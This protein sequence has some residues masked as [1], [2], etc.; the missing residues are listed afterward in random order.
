MFINRAACSRAIAPAVARAEQPHVTLGFVAGLV[1]LVALTAAS[2]APRAELWKRWAAHAPDSSATVDHSA[3]NRFVA[4]YVVLD[5]GGISRLPYAA[6][7]SEDRA[8]LDD[9]LRRLSAVRISE[10]RRDEQFAFWVNLYNALTVQVTLEHYPVASIRDIR[11]SPGLFSSGPW[12]KKL[13]G[14]EGEALSL[15]DIEHRILRPIWRDPRIHYAVNCASL[16]CPNLM[17][18]AFTAR[19][20]STLLDRGA[21]AYVNHVRGARVDEGRLVVSSIYEW[22]KDDF[23]GSDRAV[24]EHLRSYADPRLAQDLMAVDRISDDNYDW[25]LNDVRGD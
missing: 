7:T 14:V 4:S 11:I 15:D 25:S 19:N 16:G 5:P 24:I 9:Y 12:G 21:R 13:I 18:E 22:F 1:L 17:N 10:H 3:W 6:V 23:G 20:T 8:A 2:A